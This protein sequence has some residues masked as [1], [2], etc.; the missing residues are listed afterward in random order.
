VGLSALPVPDPVVRVAVANDRAEVLR[1]F[2]AAGLE[3]TGR[4]GAWLQERIDAPWRST[5]DAADAVLDEPWTTMLG[6][7]DGC[8]VGVAVGRTR[9]MHRDGAVGVIE[10]LY[11][12]PEGRSVGVGD[13]L[14]LDMMSHFKL[15]GC[16]GVDAWALPG[17]RE[18]KNFYEAHAFSARIITV[19]HSFIGPMHDSRTA[20]LRGSRET[21]AE[22]DAD[23][24]SDPSA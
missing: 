17:E 21:L 12:E 9:Q 16:I 8:A 6:M 19:H 7:I 23:I 15:A 1:L 20:G 18:T 2:E 13:A 3:L 5:A 11:V 24:A 10:A 14:V 22:T 4:K